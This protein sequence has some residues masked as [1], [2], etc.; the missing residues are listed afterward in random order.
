MTLKPQDQY[1]VPVDT[2]KVALAVFLKGNLCITIS[3]TLGTVLSDKAFSELFEKKGQPGGF[4]VAFGAS[5]YPTV[6]RR[7]N[8]PPS[9]GC[10]A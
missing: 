9:S 4:A 10:S 8:R 7:V 3:D 2:A 5:H 6:C 1:V